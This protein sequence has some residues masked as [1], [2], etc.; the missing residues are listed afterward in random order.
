MK[1]TNNPSANLGEATELKKT[2]AKTETPE[3]DEKKSGSLSWKSVLVAGVP[4]ILIGSVGTIAVEDAAAQSVEEP[5]A[6][7]EDQDITFEGE[8]QVAHSVTDD[9]SFSE[10]FAAARAEVGPGGAF[11]W[12]G[13]VYGTYRG[14][15]PEWVAMS[16]DDR[17][18][19][20]QWVLGQVHGEPVSADNSETQT[21][22]QTQDDTHDTIPDDQN[23]SNHQSEEDANDAHTEDSHEDGDEEG[24]DVPNEED[25]VGEVDVHIVGV[26]QVELGNGEFVDAGY[27]EVDNHGA[28]FVDV[29]GDGEVDT[30]LIDAN[31]NG[32]L[33]EDDI[34]CDLEGAGITTDDLA[35]AAEM[36]TAETLD[37]HLYEDMPDYTNDIDDGNHCC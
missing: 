32:E 3:K 31:D 4:G 17:S 11:V 16:D 33:D 25:S 35:A 2:V 29:D 10:A 36:N 24:G 7:Q 9:M 1:T 37:D 18:E 28:I 8:A 5:G 23:D 21:Q 20:S 15:D 14:D 22:E 13:H 34:I 6:E 30:V 27:G 26:G 19:Y 12:H